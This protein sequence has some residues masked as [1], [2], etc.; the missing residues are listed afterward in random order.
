MGKAESWEKGISKVFNA[1]YKFVS[2]GLNGTSYIPPEEVVDVRCYL[3][4]E[5]LLELT[6]LLENVYDKIQLENGVFYDNGISW[7]D[8]CAFNINKTY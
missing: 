8:Y 4:P 7:Y 1:I 2:D 5:E 6:R 3:S